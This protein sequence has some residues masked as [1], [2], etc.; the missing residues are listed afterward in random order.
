[1]SP[2][3]TRAFA[4]R[5]AEDD[6]FRARVAQDPRAALAEYGVAEEPGLVPDAVVLPAKAELVALGLDKKSR[7]RSRAGTAARANE[8]DA[9]QRPALRPVVDLASV[10]RTRHLLLR[11][12]EEPGA[13]VAA[14][15][16]GQA[17][18]A[19]A[20]PDVAV[21]GPDRGG[22]GARGGRARPAAR[23]SDRPLG[24]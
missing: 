23:R 22:G 6:A 13:D 8:A 20:R 16:R 1:M 5:L 11:C 19:P 14:L 17:R 21:S 2:N 7:S 4:A 10:R 9:G 12:E 18:L 24:A 3:S 15:L